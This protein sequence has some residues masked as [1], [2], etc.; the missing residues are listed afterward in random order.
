MHRKISFIAMVMVLMSLFALGVS[1]DTVTLAQTVQAGKSGQYELE[2]YNESSASQVYK[3]TVDGFPSGVT[4]TFSQGGPVLSEITVPAN[5]FS[6]VQLKIS[7]SADTPEGNY[8]GQF[9]AVRDDGTVITQDLALKVENQYALKIT[10]QTMNVS[11]F[12]GQSFSV[13]ITA[14]N[15]GSAPLS[16]VA[17]AM[18]VPAKWI[19]TTT[20]QK[21]DSLGAGD[22]VDF[23]VDVLIPTSQP[24]IDQSVD[25]KITSDQT[26]SEPGKLMVRVQ[27]SPNYLFASGGL[28]IFALGGV[29][30]YFRRKGRR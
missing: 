14:A 15:S 21:A 16:N 22:T 28:V 13:N 8:I 10:S 12:S 25:L 24:A 7:V 18:D 20:P 27:K 9:F 23:K 30:V 17:V 19:V 5:D 1:A 3:L 2:I 6:I 4:T 29:F 11:A 26:E